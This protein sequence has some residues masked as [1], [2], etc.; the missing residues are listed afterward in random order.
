[1]DVGSR[2][3]ASRMR[4]ALVVSPGGEY[5]HV[6]EFVFPSRRFRHGVDD[7]LAELIVGGVGGGGGV[8]GRG[9]E[10]APGLDVRPCGVDS[11]TIVGCFVV[12]VDVM[13]W[14][15]QAEEVMVFGEDETD[16]E[17]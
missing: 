9:V 11:N 12:V 16:D 15:R 7:G 13:V 3:Y 1:M 17:A 10:G 14:Q 6:L 5:V 8:R 2:A 4:H